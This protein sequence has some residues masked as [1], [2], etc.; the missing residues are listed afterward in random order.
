MNCRG[1]AGPPSDFQTEV[2]GGPMY[3]KGNWEITLFFSYLIPKVM[4]DLEHFPFTCQVSVQ[5]CGW[6]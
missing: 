3:S 2:V 6:W 4:H 1:N 5:W